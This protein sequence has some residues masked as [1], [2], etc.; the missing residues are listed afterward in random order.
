[1]SD[2]R[3]VI[4]APKVDLNQLSRGR[5][6]M[7]EALKQM[8]FSSMR[9]GQADVISCIMAGRDTICVLPT[10]CHAKG[11]G[12]LMAD[13]SVKKV[14]N[15]V[16]G[17]CVMGWDGTIRRVTHLKHGFGESSRIKPLR[18]NSFVVADDHL[19]TLVRT[20]EKANP[21]YPCQMRDGEVLD[22]TVRE[23]RTW[24]KWQKHIHKLFAVSVPI[25]HR[26]RKSMSIEP[27]FM[28]VVLGDGSFR[29]QAL[30]VSKPDIE[31]E[32][33]CRRQAEVWGIGFTKEDPEDRCASYRLHN[34]GKRH[35]PLTEAL[36]GLGL[37]GLGSPE[38]FI[39][40]VYKYAAL[41]D[42]QKLVAG[43]LDTDGHKAPGCY[44]FISASK[45][46][47][48]DLVFVCRSIG[49]HAADAK[50]CTK[51]C[52]D[53]TGTYWRVCVSGSDLLKL[54]LRIARKIP[55]PSVCQKKNVLRC[56][57][58]VEPV[59]V[60]EFFGFTI[61]GDGRYLMDDFTVTH[62][63]GKT[64]CFVLPTLALEWRTL[65]FSP[66]ISLMRDQ[67]QSLAAKGV[68]VGSLTSHDPAMNDQYIKAWLRGEIQVLYVAPER[69]RREDFL[70]AM[71]QVPPDFVVMDEAH[72][73]PGHYSVP[74]EF[75]GMTL[76]AMH[77]CRLRGADVPRVW[78][79]RAD[80][81]RELRAVTM[82][83]EH[84]NT[85][86]DMVRVKL[87]EG[88][89]FECT[90]D[91]KC[92]TEHGE[93]EAE[94]LRQ[95]DLVVFEIFHTGE[96][97][98]KPL[99]KPP[100]L[101]FVKVHSVRR[102]DKTPEAL[103][104]I[105]VDGNHNFYVS[106]KL[107]NAFVP[108]DQ[109]DSGVAVLV[110]NC[111][112]SWSDN[113]RSAYCI[114]GDFIRDMNPNVV[115]TFTA[116]CPPEVELDIRR[117]MCIQK[118]IKTTYY[119][120]RNNL[121]LRSQPFPGEPG[122]ATLLERVNG[123][124]VIYCASV[125]RVEQLAKDL[126]NL[127]GKEVHFYHGQLPK[128]QRSHTQDMFA[129]GEAQWMVATN[130]FGMGVDVP[131]IRL[132][133]HFDV[134]DSI[135]GLAQEAGRGGRD[136]KHTLCMAYDN[137]DTVGVRNFLIRMSNPDPSEVE[138]IYEAMLKNCDT[139]GR[140]TV[141]VDEL[142]KRAGL[143]VVSRIGA[144]LQILGGSL[145][146]DRKRD[147]EKRGMVKWL[148]RVDDP[149]L[150]RYMDAAR[151]LGEPEQDGFIS[152]DLI[153]WADHLGVGDASLKSFLRD[154]T[155]AH[156]LDYIP[157][158]RAAPIK[159]IGDKRLINFERI[160]ERQDR[161]LAKFAQVLRYAREIPDKDKHSYIEAML[162]M[163]SNTLGATQP[164]Q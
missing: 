100:G 151:L 116:T 84:R 163:D 80:G 96:G 40:D 34:Y 52:G 12:I 88:S 98:L 38:K 95:G 82:T 91:H 157:P 112:S 70:H 55:D 35:N 145:V 11:Q 57:F 142:C 75:G 110:H 147:D 22:V 72:C 28:G 43:L 99:A 102:L 42:R 76:K 10:A 131:N 89:F 94:S 13:G 4:R 56:G 124:S 164:A 123:P 16:V 58:K 31:I 5:A 59:G 47:S 23:Y 149:K 15:I 111:L 45:R 36:R 93:V 126:G 50:E 153:A 139:S 9:Q 46:L 62:N 120:R 68:R 127:T 19:L 69:L 32:M 159:V 51:S 118:A 97:N 29:K 125:K 78:S 108:A 150:Q 66:L 85:T 67:V 3:Y 49:L 65:V 73:F 92:F 104:D 74:T 115:A 156:I 6:N 143:R 140:V 161:A 81:H 136:G 160:Q 86:K 133:V 83:W 64:A 106:T 41:E 109:Y 155:A 152:V 138:D 146:I 26:V 21:K 122:L 79:R 144:I 63:T 114:V 154:K 37:W 137:K 30:E 113:F 105:E 87:Q 162:G 8:G 119:P 132:V 148:N 130:A 107:Q 2:E 1:M 77:E 121:D 44:D 158:D 128:A 60:Q 61:T 39:P 27:Y 48:E 134:S 103:Y 141:S 7:P 17:D 14:E 25:F 71:R 33:E 101:K 135:E 20:K 129:R 117:V 90:A 53:F 54:G 18:R 24:S